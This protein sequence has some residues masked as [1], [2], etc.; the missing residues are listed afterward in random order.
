MVQMVIQRISD[1]KFAS[2]RG[3]M[4][5]ITDAEFFDDEV[6]ALEVMQDYTKSGTPC[7]LLYVTITMS[8][9]KG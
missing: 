2:L 1:K 6:H 5:H 4:N 3:F 7:E 9:V 8:N